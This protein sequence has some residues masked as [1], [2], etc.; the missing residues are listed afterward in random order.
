MKALITAEIDRRTIHELE[1][2]GYQVETAGWG[3]T[4]Q[5]LLEEELAPQLEGTELLV[6]ELE[7]ITSTLLEM[8]QELK[9]IFV[10]RSAPSIVDLQAATERGIAVLS[11]PARNAN[12]VAEFTIGLLLNAARNISR[13]E[14]HLR[15]EGWLVNGELPYFHF[16]GPELDGKVLGLIGC[17]AIGK[18]ILRRVVGFGLDIE[19]FD[20]YLS[21]QEIGEA[22]KLTSLEKVLRHSDFLLLL[23]SLTPETE[24]MIGENELMLMKPTSFLINTARAAILIEDALFEALER[25]RIAGAALD[26]FWREPLPPDDRWLTLDNVLLTPHLA[27]ASDEVATHQGRMLIEDL[28]SLRLGKAPARM[29]NPSVLGSWV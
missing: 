12:S 14:R 21:Q 3:Q 25:G 23:C 5:I 15:E 27:G 28:R 6:V 8:A 9:I 26:V 29:A 7:H 20:P 1:G 10:C 18:A 17:G 22:G 2:L 24:G 13:S 16:R 19:I 4:H 11:A